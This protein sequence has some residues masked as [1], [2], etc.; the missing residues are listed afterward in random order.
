MALLILYCTSKGSTAGIANRI[1]DRLSDKLQSVEVHDLQTFDASTLDN[2]TAF[3]I[4]SC[5]HGT[6]WLKEAKSFITANKAALTSRM[7]FAFSV[8][9][10]GAWPTPLTRRML[11]SWEER[12]VGAE[13]NRLLDGKVKHH[14]LFNGKLE[15]EVVEGCGCWCLRP[16]DYRE[17]I[18]VEAWADGL[19]D[20]FKGN[21]ETRRVFLNL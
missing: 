5:V 1:R 21:E 13:L 16:G 4:G 7:L 2:Y 9:A 6:A 18:E 3:I 20:A 15:E 17:W 19:V 10:P 12:K 14:T 11:K 8:G